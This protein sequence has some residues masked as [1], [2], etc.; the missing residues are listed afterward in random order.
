[1][2]GPPHSTC[3]PPLL[4]DTEQLHSPFRLQEG[5]VGLV[6]N[7][8]CNVLY[9]QRL[10]KSAAYSVQDEMLCAGDFSTGKAI[11]QVSEAV[12]LSPLP[13]PGSP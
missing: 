2:A 6:G 5:K 8:L 4:V 1:M 3:H 9:R 13:A 7:E 11:C 12:S 10:S